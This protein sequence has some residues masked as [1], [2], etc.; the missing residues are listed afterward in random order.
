[1]SEFHFYS[2]VMLIKA[3]KMLYFLKENP[4]KH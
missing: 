3:P 1:M 2:D 4:L